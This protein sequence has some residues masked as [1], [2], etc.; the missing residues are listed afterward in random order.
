MD[1]QSILKKYIVEEFMHELDPKILNGEYLLIE[2]GVIDSMGL[3]RLVL[4]IEEKFG[5]TIEEDELDIENFGTLDAM[6]NFISKKVS[7]N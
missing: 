7:S 3:V 1:V 5:I 6:T 2:N 4:F